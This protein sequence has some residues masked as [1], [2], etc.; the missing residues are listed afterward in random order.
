VGDNPLTDIA[1]ANAAGGP[2]KSALVRTGMFR[3]AGNDAANPAH[4]VEDDILKVVKHVL[5]LHGI[6]PQL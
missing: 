4:I 6:A 3:G 1:G 2:W 5:S